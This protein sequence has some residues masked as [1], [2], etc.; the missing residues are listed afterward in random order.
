MT[1]KFAIAARSALQAGITSTATSL[2][3]ELSK[4]DLFPV[5][6]TG[7]NAVGTAGK[8]WF[9][10]VLEDASHNI[11]VIYVRT[12]EAG[13][14][15]FSNVLRGQEGTTARA[16]LAGSIVGL[17]HT[18]TDLEDAISFASGAS[19]FWKTLVGWTT[20]ALSRAALG[21]TTIGD[22]LFTAG[23][24]AA[25]R[26]TLGASSIGS[27][28]FTATNQSEAREAIGA[29]DSSLDSSF[30]NRLIN[31]AGLINQRGVS[32]TVT[33]A[34]GAYGHDRFKAGAS[35]CTYT[36]ATSNNLTTFTIS[37]GS[38]IQVIEGLNLEIGIYCL[39]WSG[40][41]QGKIAGGTF[42]VSGV[43]VFIPGGI[44]TNIEFSTGTLTA[45][46]FE[47]GNTPTGFDYR[48]Y[49]VEEM[50]CLRYL[51]SYVTFGSYSQPV[52]APGRV[53]NTQSA[54]FVF[55]YKVRPRVPPT[56]LTISSLSNFSVS[57]STGSSTLISVT[58]AKSGVDAITIHVVT[59]YSSFTAGQVAELVSSPGQYILFTGCEL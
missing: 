9:K 55:I 51:P 59:E 58:Y 38:L 25:A 48:P 34:A 18:A 5:A 39:S 31:A 52:P 8:D 4:A 20:A 23:S 3:I 53:L 26:S 10:A 7:T 19:S 42:T 27:A 41:A 57:A 29:L 30:K 12:R 28:V 36:F 44:N 16:Y 50:L 35:G 2:S 17:R 40:T 14:A 13:S 37:A 24:A 54:Q 21:A 6:N 32:G 15:G 11:E 43:S 56:G 46:Q 49:A 22:A 45:P 33:L 47:K 1:Q